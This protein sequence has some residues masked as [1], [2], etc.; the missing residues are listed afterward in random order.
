MD[1]R[2]KGLRQAQTDNN[3]HFA[4]CHPELLPAVGRCRRTDKKN[5]FLFHLIGLINKFDKYKSVIES[6]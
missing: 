5:Q 6:H 2:F 3:L 4:I 1:T